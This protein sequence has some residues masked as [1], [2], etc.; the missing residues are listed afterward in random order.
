MEIIL[1]FSTLKYITLVHIQPIKR[2]DI[3]MSYSRKLNVCM[4]IRES[5]IPKMRESLFHLLR[6]DGVTCDKM[7]FFILFATHTHPI[8]ASRSG[9][10]TTYHRSPKEWVWSEKNDDFLGSRMS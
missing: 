7:N 6:H 5:M 1:K 8:F 2:F 4:Y 3:F 10:P 9:I